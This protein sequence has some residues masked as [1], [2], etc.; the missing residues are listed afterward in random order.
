[1][2]EWFDKLPDLTSSVHT[3]L[4]VPTQQRFDLI[5]TVKNTVEAKFPDKLACVVQ[6]HGQDRTTLLPLRQRTSN[7]PSYGILSPFGEKKGADAKTYLSAFAKLRRR[8]VAPVFFELQNLGV[9]S[10]MPLL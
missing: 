10:G 3:S 5:N 7:M 6:C 2:A 9:A 4:W 8:C 1:M